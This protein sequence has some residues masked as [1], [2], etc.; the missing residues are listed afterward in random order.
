[1]VEMLL[2]GAIVLVAAFYS[3]WAL[4]PAPARQRLAR[5]LLGLS[6]AGWC[7]D[8]IGRRIRTTAS[9]PGTSG[10]PCDGCSSGQPN[11]RI[12]R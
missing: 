5:R 3:T 10:S 2:V 6:E 7:P 11:D 4:M 1:M 9:G 12:S 8:W